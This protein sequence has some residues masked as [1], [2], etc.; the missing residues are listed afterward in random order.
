VGR[1]SG[2]TTLMTKIQRPKEQPL[3]CSFLFLLS[4]KE[5]D[6]GDPG[7][8]GHARSVAGD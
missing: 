2:D 7:P 3:G 8:A 1:A 6:Q 4:Q 5:L